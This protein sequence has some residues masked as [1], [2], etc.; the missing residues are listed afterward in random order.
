MKIDKKSFYAGCHRVRAFFTS[1]EVWLDYCQEIGISSSIPLHE[2]NELLKVT[3]PKIYIPLWASACKNS[4]SILQNETTLEVISFY[5]RHGF[6]GE[7]VDGNPLDYIG[8]Q[9]RFLEY[10]S[11]LTVRNIK[12]CEADIHEFIQAFTLDTVQAMMTAAAEYECHED[13]LGILEDVKML[14]QQQTL[15]VSKDLSHMNTW[16][17]YK[18]NIGEKIPL[19]PSKYIC[20]SGINNCG[21]KCRINVITQEGCLLNLDTDT[22]S[23]ENPEIR[24]CVR[25]KGY[26][27]TY[28]STDRLRYPLKRVGERGSGKFERISWNEAVDLIAGEMKRIKETYGSQSRYPIYATGVTSIMRPQLLAAN[29][30]ALDGGY[31]GAYN[32]YSSG[33]ATYVMP[34]VYGD[35]WKNNVIEDIVNTKLLILWG[36]N[37]AETIFGSYTNYYISQLRKKGVPIVV[38]DP[39]ESDSA[40][41]YGDEWIPIRPSTD[42]AMI[43]AMAYVIFKEGLEDREFINKFCVG[44]D[45]DHMPEGVPK[46]ENYKD[47]LFGKKDGIEK[48]TSWAEEICGV[49]A[50]TIESLAKRYATA[51]PACILP[52]LGPQ[53]TGNGEQSYRGFTM[54]C[55][56]TGNVGVSGGST[57]DFVGSQAVRPRPYISMV[58]NPYPGKIPTFLWTKAIEKGKQMDPLEDGLKGVEN[59]GADIKMIFNLAGNTLINQ[60]SDINDTIRILKDTSKCEFIVTSDVFMT[61][62]AKYSDLV[63]PASSMFEGNNIAHPWSGENY[64][65]YNSKVMEPLFECRFEYDWLK[66]VAQKM[67]LYEEFTQGHETTEDWL[68]HSYESI[69]PLEKELP[70]YDEFIKQGGY[71]YKNSPEVLPYLDQIQEGKPFKTP[72]GKIEIFS[73]NLYDMNQHEKIPGIP[74]YTPCVEGM[75]DPLT[76]EFPLQLIGY[77]TKRRCHSIHD[78]ND[79]MEELDPPAL[80]I[81]PQDARV[82]GIENGMMIDVFNNRGRV[83]IPTKVTTRIAKGVVALSQGGWYTPNEDGVDIRGSIN[84][85]THTTPTPLAKANPQHTNLVEVEISRKESNIG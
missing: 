84:V 68:R 83:R 59:L 16:D 52:G 25:G 27:R 50:K 8:E 63:L 11:S 28:L 61:S 24:S 31:L 14:I 77:H 57:G 70:P 6:I 73:K 36:H 51:K 69:M 12:D 85:L 21:G 71:Q 37:P 56:L 7:A 47:Y 9:F 3:N 5:K 54:L 41:G 2:Y 29:L 46:E 78:N 30:M 45:S 82:R 4:G 48:T 65:L 10:L 13:F 23:N 26:K 15:D 64:I 40:I 72:T 58:P 35:A 44:F 38:I 22:R 34:Y 53:R 75:E 79:W 39:R 67:G 81:H 60:H 80:W 74:S 32:S 19:E 43:D 20:S 33:C 66:E 18:W 76:A 62:S 17:S 42:G 49:P 55:S 1:H